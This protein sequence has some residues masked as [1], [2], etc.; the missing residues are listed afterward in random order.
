MIARLI[1]HNDHPSWLKEPPAI[2]DSHGVQH[3]VGLHHVEGHVV[4]ILDAWHTYIALKADH[5]RQLLFSLYKTFTLLCHIKSE[6][7]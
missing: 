5:L 3:A 4:E 7:M 6:T 1:L 2:L